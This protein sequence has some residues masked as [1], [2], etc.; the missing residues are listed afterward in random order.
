MSHERREDQICGTTEVR[1]C[2]TI[3]RERLKRR[4]A[5]RAAVERRRVLM[6]KMIAIFNGGF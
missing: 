2:R 1:K 5:D 6:E 4:A 3:G